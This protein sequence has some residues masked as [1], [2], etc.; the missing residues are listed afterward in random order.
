[1][2]DISKIKLPSGNEYN[3]KDDKAR[4]DI[5]ALNTAVAS[6]ST[7]I[8][9]LQQM[10][11]GGVSFN[12]V[13]TA[14]DYASTS[15]PTAAKKSI[16]PSGVTVYYN[17]GAN[18]TTGTLAASDETI[19]KF[20]L[21]YSKTQAGTL[22]VFDEYITV[23]ESTKS[24]EK[25]GDTLIDLSNVVTNVTLNKQ[26]DTV[27]GSGATFT[28]T[29]PTVVISAATSTDPGAFSVSEFSSGAAHIKATA[30]NG[31]VAWNSMDTQHPAK[32]ITVTT[33]KISAT[34]LN[35]GA[36]WD[37]KDSK[38][39]LT[40]V[41]TNNTNIKA[42][43]TGGGAAWNN[44]DSKTVVTGVQA[45]TT[46]I[47]AEASGGGAAWNSKDVKT[48]LTGVKTNN[49]YL[50]AT[51]NTGTPSWSSKDTKTVVSGVTASQS[52]LATSTV[53]GVQAAT[54]TA[55]KAT[56]TTTQTTATGGG[57]TSTA[58]TDW[59]KGV[60]VANEV[61]TI[62]AATMETQ[63]T[64]QFTFSDVTVP[65]KNASATTVATGQLVASG[66]GATV[67]TNVSVGSSVDVIGNNAT[68]NPASVNIALSSSE[69]S[70]I[71][72]I[73][74]A[75]GAAPN[76]A[77]SVIGSGA[78]LTNTQ[79]T[80]ALSSGAATGAGVISVAYDA[81]ATGTANVIGSSATLTNT[82]PTVALSSGAT[83][84]TGVVSVA[85]SA[86]AANTASVIGSEATLTN[87]QPTIAL[88]SGTVGDVTVVTNT[89][90]STRVGVIGSNATFKVTQPTIALSSDGTG[91]TGEVSVLTDPSVTAKYFKATAS[92]GNVAWNNKDQV[93]ALTSTTSL[94]VTKG[95]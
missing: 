31:G 53:T 90:I 77:A 32:E 37:N 48:V 57:N 63:S 86:A 56:A 42:T 46:N 54:T 22:D 23:G 76:G 30:T 65:I 45:S 11:A 70:T 59:L 75:Y 87:T 25:I 62:G 21:I 38:T 1:M 29:Q 14:A 4:T 24:W 69:T 68:L 91:E 88:S 94:T 55:S 83:A 78:T 33:T 41:K 80:I 15:A 74:V 89:E 36:A 9:E 72:S 35:G 43:A 61:L 18:S 40:G 3:I 50:K 34:A 81:A 17:N 8:S 95:Q 58:N 66:G 16:I 79:P 44:K 64:T 7:E 6:H 47:K 52:N 39:V 84:G 12:I 28:V 73:S 85:Y 71:G 92:G 27:I 93:T 13:W 2:A 60:S 20:Y 82:Q 26:T 5:G 10:I 49:M 51:A 19:G 67:A